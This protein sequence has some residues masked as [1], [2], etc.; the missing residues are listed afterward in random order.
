[1]FRLLPDNTQED[2]SK[3]YEEAKSCLTLE[4]SRSD[5]GSLRWCRRRKSFCGLQLDGFFGAMQPSLRA[6][7]GLIDVLWSGAIFPRAADQTDSPVIAGLCVQPCFCFW[8]QWRRDS[9]WRNHHLAE[10]LRHPFYKHRLEQRFQRSKFR[11]TLT[12]LGNCFE[13]FIRPRPF[14]LFTSLRNWSLEF[15]VEETSSCC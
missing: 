14:R 6:I 11:R 2:R 13:E 9:T 3:Q 15:A 8:K 10:G 7:A 4:S 1:M 5:N 12:L